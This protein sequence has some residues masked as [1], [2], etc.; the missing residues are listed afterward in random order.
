M[1]RIDELVDVY[2]LAWTSPDPAERARALA[3]VWAPGA[4]Y[5]DPTVDVTG[6]EALLAHID[7]VLARRPGARVVRTSAVDSHHGVA[8]FAWCVVTA[9]GQRPAGGHRFQW[10]RTARGASRAS[11]DSSARSRPCRRGRHGA[12]AGGT[13]NRVSPVATSCMLPPSVVCSSQCANTTALPFLV[14][15]ARAR[16]RCPRA[17]RR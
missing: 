6:A 17:G 1:T 16:K 8:R 13:V 10:R 11:S 3:S 4:R 15:R 5:T 9:D 14:T 12:G 7:K 2:C